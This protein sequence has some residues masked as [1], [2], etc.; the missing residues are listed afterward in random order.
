MIANE[1]KSIVNAIQSGVP[2]GMFR[3]GD[4]APKLPDVPMMIVADDR[5]GEGPLKFDI[6]PL[7][8][9]VNGVIFTSPDAFEIGGNLLSISARNGQRCLLVATKGDTLAD[10]LEIILGTP[11]MSNYVLFD[12]GQNVPKRVTEIVGE[13][14]R[15]KEGRRH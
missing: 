11:L 4:P 2:L 3:A 13:I 8:A 5:N 12:V 10:W 15:L 1:V 6:G 9:Q 7:L 14:E